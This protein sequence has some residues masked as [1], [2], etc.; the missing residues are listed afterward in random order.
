MI[1]PSRWSPA[2]RMISRACSSGMPC[3]RSS[4]G[5][6][7]SRRAAGLDQRGGRPGAAVTDSRRCGHLP[8]G[9]PVGIRYKTEGSPSGSTPSTA[10]PRSS[11]YAATVSRLWKSLTTNRGRAARHRFRPGRKRGHRR[12]ARSPHRHTDVRKEERAYCCLITNVR[13][14]LRALLGTRR[15]STPSECSSSTRA[16][17]VRPPAA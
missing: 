4:A 14:R 8:T 5:P 7:R 1:T 16:V 9:A 6:A 2:M 17:P 12:G 13:L 15:S 3:W 10:T 11:T